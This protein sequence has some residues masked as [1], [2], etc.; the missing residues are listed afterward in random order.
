MSAFSQVSGPDAPRRRAGADGGA[1]G[2]IDAGAYTGH[3]ARSCAGC[4][5]N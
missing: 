3:C 2:M 1:E 4:A 5:S